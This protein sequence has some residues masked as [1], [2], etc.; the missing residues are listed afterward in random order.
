MDHGFPTTFDAAARRARRSL[1]GGA[2]RMCLALGAAA[3]AMPAAPS[4][5]QV[6]IALPGREDR[7][8]CVVMSGREFDGVAEAVG[9]D[10]SQRTTA[11][12]MFDDAQARMFEAKRTADAAARKVGLFEPSREA[13]AARGA[14]MRALRTSLLAQ[15][16]DLFASL[17]A[18]A[19]PE[20][21]PALLHERRVARL[22]VI[23]T[24]APE[25]GF[26]GS[27]TGIVVSDAVAAVNAAAIDGTDVARA[28]E[29][30]AG[31]LDRL[32]D[33][34]VR[35]ADACSERL[36]AMAEAA[37]APDSDPRVTATRTQAR[38]ARMQAARVQREALMQASRVQRESLAAL[39][40]VLT[41]TALQDA[42]AAAARAIWPM[43][44]DSKSPRRAIGQLL[45]RETNADRRTALE[46]VRD[47][48]WAA[49]WPA[50]LRIIDSFE[51]VL[52]EADAMGHPPAELVEA[53]T[54]ADR[55]AW[56]ALAA[57]DPANKDF[58]LANAEPSQALKGG[59]MMLDLGPNAEPG[60]PGS[61]PGP[62]GPSLAT[63]VS[64][65][66][67]ST[68]TVQSGESGDAGGAN[69]EMAVAD[70]APDAGEAGGAVAIA[71]GDAL[72]G[73]VSNQVTIVGATGSADD[74][75]ID[76]GGDMGDVAEMFP[77]LPE[78]EAVHD[79]WERHALAGAGIPPPMTDDDVRRI[80][81]AL[82][83][84]ADEG[85]LAQVAR[86]YRDRS[87]ASDDELGARIRSLLDGAAVAWPMPDLPQA[88]GLPP[89]RPEVPLADIREAV[90]LI[91][92]WTE[93]L[94]T[95]DDA[96]IDAVAALGT[97]RPEAV[98]AQQERRARAR[99]RALHYPGTGGGF[100]LSGLRLFV[101]PADALAASGADAAAIEAAGRA[102]EA[103]SPAALAA[104]EA[105]RAAVRKES[106]ALIEFERAD[107]A[108]MRR[109]MQSDDG[110]QK[111][112]L[113]DEEPMERRAETEGRLGK[114]RQ[115]V[116]QQSVAGRDA[117]E[118]ALP[119]LMRGAFRSAWYSLSVPSAYRDRSDAL[120]AVDRARG[121]ADL[122]GAQRA[123]LDALRN[124]HASL[125]RASCDAIAE[126][127][128]A[129]AS[130]MDAAMDSEEGT[131]MD[132]ITG[133]W[134]MLSDAFFERREL[135][136][137][138]LRRLRAVLTPEQAKEIPQLQ[139][140]APRRMPAGLPPGFP[141]AAPMVIPAP[142]PAAPAPTS[143]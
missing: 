131:G 60:L 68:V 4:S 11:D 57:L 78:A 85:V 137:R 43:S 2:T 24:T 10:P 136:A 132:S 31:S 7:R 66:F 58:H 113:F 122:S 75:S 41:G 21:Q 123:Q 35:L 105:N 109:A 18:I 56:Q 28:H 42:K 17:G 141:G 79:F 47:A 116:S 26:L 20:Q 44:A 86:D 94:G 29:A 38:E 117:A 112:F 54:A 1:L 49:W 114:A 39:E 121:L 32:A 118:G 69:V 110:A 142:T 53:R 25:S 98:Q 107:V 34:L 125:H 5:A 30:L 130:R 76:F 89:Q 8:S 129:E 59:G 95:L 50:T 93:Q 51:A 91:D 77:P 126:M 134:R 13:V 82:G 135:D 119:E 33:A 40:G 12:V 23:R 74:V 111:A 83:V 9:F 72:E 87:K 61:E 15:V 70:D 133:E 36:L 139:P 101:E 16:D 104:I 127:M 97:P 6:E 92:Q 3:A 48:W 138:T 46:G 102:L 100:N 103:W 62:G 124:D 90:G 45:R 96:V 73:M 19:R 108:N 140:R 88:P 71:T 52:H 80:A 67:S 63:G 81:S 22:R 106:V 143:P 55:T 27:N 115:A 120:P 84:A 14:A 99:A 64:I 37:G 65:A 128:I